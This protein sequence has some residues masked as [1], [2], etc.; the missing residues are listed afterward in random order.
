MTI[1]IPSRLALTAM[2]L[3]PAAGV[4]ASDSHHR[5]TAEVEQKIRTT[6]TEQGY[7]VRKI[8][9]EDRLFEAYA[10]KDGKRLEIY[11]DADLNVIRTKI[12]D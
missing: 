3:L 1:R 12:D 9:R 8:K 10:L 5:L 11:L 6:L 7:D 4:F 2:L